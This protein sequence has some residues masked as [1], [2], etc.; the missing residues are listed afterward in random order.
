MSDDG[1]DHAFMARALQLAR[2]GL[3]TT[4][5]N[6][7]VGCVLVRGDEIIGEGWHEYAGGPHAEVAALGS[8][9]N[10]TGA[11]AYV[12]LEPCCHHGRTPPCTDALL[13]A[14]VA[15]VVIASEDPNPDVAGEGV[16][17]LI[18][19]GVDVDCGV[20]ESAAQVLNPG[21]MK[22]MRTGLPFVRSKI[23]TSLDG[24]T[25]LANGASQ[26]I[27]GQAARDDVQRLRARSS[28]IVTGAGTVLAD[29]PSLNVRAPNLGEVRQPVRVVVDSQLRMSPQAKMLELPGEVIVMT[30]SGDDAKRAALE[31]AG[32]RVE[33]VDSTEVGRVDLES[34]LGRL[35]E[36]EINEVLVEA[37]AGLNGAMLQAGLIDELIVY[38]AG[39]VLGGDARGMFDISELVDM[40]LRKEFELG[41]V[42]H[43]GND[44]RL[45]WR[46][47]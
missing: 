13:N 19:A 1:R 18:A 37:G 31:N 14:H 35:G 47:L 3:Y 28:A 45:T 39:S 25:A 4:D 34:V 11:T 29:D 38:M 10:A 27:T 20:L 16:A 7:R 21:F 40:S 6:P 8:A 17:T 33:R 26:W 2:R 12:T 9:G 32:A 43:V 46:S 41:D 5:P 30:A 36:L 22:R 44:L 24:R 15:R 42:R 23:A